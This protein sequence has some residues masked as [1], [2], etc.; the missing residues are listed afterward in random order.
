ML[1]MTNG[2]GPFIFLIEYNMTIGYLPLMERNSVRFTNYILKRLNMELDA[3]V[4]QLNTGDS[5]ATYTM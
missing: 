4:Q 2:W 5:S 1:Y 3:G